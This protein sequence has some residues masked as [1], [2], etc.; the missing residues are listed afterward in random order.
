MRRLLLAGCCVVVLSACAG[1]AEAQFTASGFDDP[2]F[3][4][5]GFFVPQQNLYQSTPRQE[6]NLRAMAVQ[7]QYNAVTERSTLFQPTGSLLGYDA[8]ADFGN[9][10]GSRLPK[11]SAI[12]GVV[13]HV[14]GAGPPSHFNRGAGH[15]PTLR[16][17]RG[18]A[19]SGAM[20]STLIPQTSPKMDS[21]GITRSTRRGGMRGGG[22]GMG[23][24][25]G[26]GGMR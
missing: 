19:S 16:S 10:S 20:K 24:M 25:S 8:L 21:L 26:G 12:G 5:Y 18:T 9:T 1:N 13:N 14:N 2:F 17:G 23:G 4:Y 11:T 6:D 15:Y 22:G 7:R 3:L